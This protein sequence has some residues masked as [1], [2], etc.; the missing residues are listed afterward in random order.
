MAMSSHHLGD[1]RPPHSWTEHPTPENPGAKKHGQQ[2]AVWEPSGGDLGAGRGHVGRHH[3]VA[4]VPPLQ[5]ASSLNLSE[6]HPVAEP[7]SRVAIP[8]SP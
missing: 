2:G 8:P 3:L 7:G 5:G 4:T 1:F 6:V